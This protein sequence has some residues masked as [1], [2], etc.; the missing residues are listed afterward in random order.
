[1]FNADYQIVTLAAVTD[2]TSNTMAFG[3]VTDGRFWVNPSGNGGSNAVYL[4]VE[5]P[6]WNTITV[7]NDIRS[8]YPPNPW[9][10]M[11]SSSYLAALTS[12]N[13]PSSRHP[14]GL[15]VAFVDGSVHF[16]KDT[17]NTWTLVPER[18]WG[19]QVDPAWY[20]AAVAKNSVGEYL[21]TYTYT[22]QAKEGVWQAIST[23]NLGEVV[24]SDQY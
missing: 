12:S 2:G 6:L 10:Y 21:W 23:I 16:I 9:R 4:A 20:T 3:E 14:G 5:F 24:S 19:V 7:A 17:I 11:D 8:Q 22:P 1:M 18:G 13:L 15:N